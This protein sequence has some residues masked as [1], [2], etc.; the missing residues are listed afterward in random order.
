MILRLLKC[1][2]ALFC[3]VSFFP[4]VLHFAW[5]SWY[6]NFSLSFAYSKISIKAKM[7]IL[8]RVLNLELPGTIVFDYPTV[9][10]LAKFCGQEISN[11]SFASPLSTH[12]I[13]KVDQPSTICM[14][15]NSFSS[16]FCTPK[17]EIPGDGFPLSV[18]PHGR[19]DADLNISEQKLGARFG[20]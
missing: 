17:A 5:E 2:H 16:R 7:S 15:L 20:R 12:S 14:A 19:W 1:T 3:S 6:A 11:I 10:S 9:S 4:S 13:S 18:S 8:C